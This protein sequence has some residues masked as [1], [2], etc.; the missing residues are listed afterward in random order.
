MIGASGDRARRQSG[1][2]W[3]PG[4][5]RQWERSHLLEPL[6]EVGE[7]TMLF[8]LLDVDAVTLDLALSLELLEAAHDVGGETEKKG[9]K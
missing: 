3:L 9:F 7:G 6:L 1:T 4:L 2:F 5:A 8:E